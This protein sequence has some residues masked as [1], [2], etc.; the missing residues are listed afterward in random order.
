MAL[1]MAQYGTKHGHASGKMKAMQDC[2]DVEVVGIYEPDTERRRAVEES[3]PYA[4]VRFFD[5]AEEMLGDSSIEAI[6]SEGL[7][8]ESLQ[9]TATIVEAGKHVWYDKPAGD[10]W[11]CWQ[12]VVAQAE[13]NKLYIQMGYMLRYHDGFSQIAEWA[14]GGLLGDIYSV[15]AHMSTNLTPEGREVIGRSHKGG[16]FYDLAGHMLDQVVWILGRPQKTTAFLRNDSGVVENFS[17]NTLGVFEYEKAMAWVEIAAMEPRPM[18]RRFE[19]YGYSSVLRRGEGWFFPRGTDAFYRRYF[20]A[21]DLRARVGGLRR[22]RARRAFSGPTA[23]ARTARAG[24]AIACY[25]LYRRL[26][27]S[28]CLFLVRRVPFWL[29]SATLCSLGLSSAQY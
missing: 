26:A 9:Q 12:Q 17:D 6:A 1:R 11:A 16:I 20:A 2:V 28:L 23:G 27:I 3:D 25:G 4:G 22:R 13:A 15:R 5:S 29:G 7:N 8:A 24:D 19:V 10:D 18:A 14:K 21:D